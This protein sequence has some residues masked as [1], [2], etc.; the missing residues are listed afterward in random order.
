MT[1]RT[2]APASRGAYEIVQDFAAASGRLNDMA[3]DWTAGQFKASDK[4][5]ASNLLEG[6][7]RLL[8]ELRTSEANG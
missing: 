8:T 6:L 1:A 7:A 5:D 3:R 2:M 4:S